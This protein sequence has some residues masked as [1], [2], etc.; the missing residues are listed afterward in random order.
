MD[1]QSFSLWCTCS[2]MAVTTT[3]QTPTSNVRDMILGV[4]LPCIRNAR[5]HSECRVT[6]R[7]PT[8]DQLRYPNLKRMVLLIKYSCRLLVVFFL[9]W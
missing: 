4:T 5:G 9:S 1:D 7:G 3:A 6:S 8:C 2:E